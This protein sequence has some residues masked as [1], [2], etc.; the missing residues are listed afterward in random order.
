MGHKQY[1]VNEF[2]YLLRLTLFFRNDDP[3]SISPI[4]PQVAACSA[5]SSICTP[6]GTNLTN[7]ERRF[8]NR[9][10]SRI[11]RQLQEIQL[12]KFIY[13]LHKHL[14]DATVWKMARITPCYNTTGLQM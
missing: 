13:T 11:P 1:S 12:S 8:S 5:A 10:P 9:A 7:P 3:R 2:L 14:K 4:A 6:G